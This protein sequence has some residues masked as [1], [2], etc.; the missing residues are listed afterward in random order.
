VSRDRLKCPFAIAFVGVPEFFCDGS[1]L[2]AFLG[3]AQNS[4]D[5]TRY[6]GCPK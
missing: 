2:Q 5:G 3:Q 1:C 4:P 6:L